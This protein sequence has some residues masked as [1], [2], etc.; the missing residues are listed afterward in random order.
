MILQGEIME[1]N[2]SDFFYSQFK[3]K[4]FAFLSP[5]NCE[6]GQKQIETVNGITGVP[7]TF[8]KDGADFYHYHDM[9][10]LP[11]SQLKQ[12]LLKYD[13][14]LYPV[15]G[16]YF[17]LL[18][19]IRPLFKGKIIGITDIQ[20]NQIA[21]WSID[22]LQL[23]TDTLR[24]Y[25]YIMC[26][27]MDEVGTLQVALDDTRKCQY[28]GWSLYPEQLHFPHI[29]KE[30][31]IKNGICVS[32]NNPGS[33]NR[34]LLTNLQTFRLLKQRFPEVRGFMYYMTPN[35]KEKIR[36]LIDSLNIKDFELIDEVPYRECIEY[37]S[38]AY[39]AIHL[40]TFK[41]VGRLAQDCAALGVPMVG[42]VSNLPNRLCFPHTSVADYG[43]D[44][45]V[46]LAT[47]LITDKYFY[48]KVVDTAINSSLFY[49]L[50]S[51]QKRIWSLLNYDKA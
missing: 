14:F 8:K 28:T 38:N 22:D 39:M 5:Y 45:A 31:S 36:N 4:N 35:K 26:T 32:I 30:R 13:Y 33:F 10:N 42:T 46:E 3:D 49:N 20:T 23:F 9:K 24:L 21:Y 2:F 25:D 17:K 12:I 1:S 19:R 7:L 50:E 34:D 47:R 6:F 11:D 27:N 40:Y 16:E 43:I 18:H 48:D 51:T 15:Y 37:L 41:V 29:K 44:D